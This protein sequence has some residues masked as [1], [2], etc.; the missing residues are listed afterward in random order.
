MQPAIPNKPTDK[1]NL[2]RFF[3]TLRESLL[4]YLPAYKGQDVYSRGKDVE[5]KAFYYVSE[6][7]QIIREWVGSVYHRT[8]HEGLCVPELGPG[9]FSPAEM[10]EIGLARSGVLTLP[11]RADLAFEF[12][13]VKWRT[14]QHY[15]V[16]VN[17]RRYDG[18]ALNGFRDTR[19]PY[20]GEH[21]GLWPLSIDTHDVRFLYFRNIDTN[22]WHRLD[23]EH[24]A[25]LHA[26]FSQDAADYAKQVSVRLNRHVDPA[27][28]VH[29]LLQA[30]SQDA[31]LTRRDRVLAKRICSL[32]AADTPPGIDD[33]GSDAERMTASVPA[34]IDL[35]ARRQQTRTPVA[36][37]LDD[38]FDRYY[39]QRP[40]E[41]A[42]EVFD[43]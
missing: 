27:Q 30:W 8:K 12:L 2:E 10:W 36:D 18:P 6:L 43:E 14:I 17:G 37:D 29:D 4:Q 34:V 35:F 41:A 39:A 33:D 19:S 13:D 3:R 26:P 42:F 15:G 32:R 23:W 9:H 7:E 24:A 5:D 25:G 11:A 31:V 38:V 1:P 22:E 40:D 16:E 21:A 28:A 20:G